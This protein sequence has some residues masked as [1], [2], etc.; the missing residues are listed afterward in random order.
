MSKYAF[1]TLVMNVSKNFK[2]DRYVPGALVLA[3][4]LRKVTSYDLVV[5]HDGT[6]TKESISALKKL[7]DHVVHVDYITGPSFTAIQTD[8]QKSRY[9]PWIKYSYT[10]WRCLG[11]TQY[12]AVCFMDADNLPLPGNNLDN[13]FNK[14]PSACFKSIAQYTK[15][16]EKFSNKRGVVIPKYLIENALTKRGFILNGSLVVLPTGGMNRYINFIE[17][18][19]TDL[20]PSLKCYSGVDEISITLFMLH[21]GYSWYSLPY[22]DISISWDESIENPRIIT[23]FGA[24]KPWE[25]PKEKWPDLI[26]YYDEINDLIVDYPI[27]EEFFPYL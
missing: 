1:V 2:R 20:A 11:L 23:F 27:M 13:L 14:V 18:T 21:E 4:A 9:S 6:L 19:F 8:V 10:K 15:F 7:Y 25:I 22:R 5:M 12:E 16:F 26:H 24:E 17:E 3:H